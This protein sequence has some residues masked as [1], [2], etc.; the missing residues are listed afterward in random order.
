[1]ELLEGETL[2]ERLEQAGALAPRKAIE[3]AMQ[4]ARGLAAAHERGIVHRDLKPENL[5]ITRDGRVK[6]LDFGLA[7]QDAAPASRRDRRRRTPTSPVSSS[8]RPATWRPSRC[9]ASRRPPAR[10]SSRSASVVYEMLTGAHP[11]LRG[12]TAPTR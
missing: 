1:M 9:S 2:R 4:I 12:T 7:Q 3:Y 8:A 5:F 6:I 10:T 11:F